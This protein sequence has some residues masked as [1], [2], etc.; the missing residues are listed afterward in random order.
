MLRISILC[1]LGLTIEV[2][3]MK[4]PLFYDGSIVVLLGIYVN[5][6]TF[7]HIPTGYLQAPLL[8][9]QLDLANIGQQAI[10]LT[11]RA[12]I[13][14]AQQRPFLFHYLIL[15]CPFSSAFSQRLKP[16]PIYSVS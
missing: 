7:K 15:L 8:E 10:R 5:S 11:Q 13:L 4:A 14:Q 9:I 3:A 1:D 16:F 12:L 6:F 2:D